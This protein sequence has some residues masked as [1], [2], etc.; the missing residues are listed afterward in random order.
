LITAHGISDA[1]RKRLLDAD[2]TLIDTTCPLVRRVHNAA[3]ELQAEGRHILLIGKAGHVEVRGIVE[4]LSS[5]DVIADASQ[6]RRFDS[7]RLGILCQTTAPPDLVTDVRAQIEF[8]NPNADIRFVDTICRPTKLRQRAMLELVDRV[9]AVVVVGGRNSN[10]T[11]RLVQLCRQNLTPA[12]H[13]EGADD[14]VPEWF[15]TF[16]TV[17][18][19]AGTSTLDRTIDEVHQTLE[20]I[21]SHRQEIVHAPEVDTARHADGATT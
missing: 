16:H 20:R 13:V 19:T 10:N 17:G 18:L 9:D 14:L 12:L 2:K 21:G 15:D 5:C 3:I 11:R 4:D 6:V 1:E 8:D 7:Q